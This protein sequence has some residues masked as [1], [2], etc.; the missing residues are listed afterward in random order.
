MAKS[1]LK[2]NTEAVFRRGANNQG[3]FLGSF[4]NLGGVMGETPGAC[5]GALLDAL[6]YEDDDILH[7]ENKLNHYY[8]DRKLR[9]FLEGAETMQ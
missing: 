2:Q 7:C 8:F 6:R 9:L 4:L 5:Q 3:H 1:H